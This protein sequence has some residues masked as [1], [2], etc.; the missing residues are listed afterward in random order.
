MS[1]QHIKLPLSPSLLLW[2]FHF[3]PREYTIFSSHLALALLRF[4]TVPHFLFDHQ[5]K[6]LLF[7]F[8]FLPSYAS[9]CFSLGYYKL[10]ISGLLK[11]TLLIVLILVF[12]KYYFPLVIFCQRP[13]LLPIV[14]KLIFKSLSQETFC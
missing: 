9:K 7:F 1:R 13:P 3:L 6:L 12:L 14:N 2:C 4:F 8:F 11:F 10:L 5:Y